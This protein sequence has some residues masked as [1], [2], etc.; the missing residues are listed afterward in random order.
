MVGGSS[1]RKGM[2]LNE[3]LSGN[4]KELLHDPPILAESRDFTNNMNIN[5]TF[6]HHYPTNIS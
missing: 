2:D 6:A 5:N 3:S 1:H 4:N